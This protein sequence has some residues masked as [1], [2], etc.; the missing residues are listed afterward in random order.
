AV[1]GWARSVLLV[2]TLTTGVLVVLL[3]ALRLCGGSTVQELSTSVES[4]QRWRDRLAG[5][6]PYWSGGVLGV[7][8]GILRLYAHPRGKVRLERAFREVYEQQMNDLIARAQR[9]ELLEL[10]PTPEMNQLA[11]AYQ[12][13][14]Q[15]LAQVE[16]D[17]TLTEAE[18]QAARGEIQ[19]RLFFLRGNWGMIDLHRRLTLRADPDV[20]APP[21]PHTRLR[22]PH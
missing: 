17:P 4:L 5:F 21:P 15:V 9:G 10:P 16:G 19:R 8:G 22:Q 18:R 1:F 6:S 20:A 14:Q 13:G 12:H 7:L 2:A 3:L 11:E